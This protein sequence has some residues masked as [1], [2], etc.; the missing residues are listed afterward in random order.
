LTTCFIII[1]NN[2][3][4]M[5]ML[6]CQNKCFCDISCSRKKIKVNQVK[7][8]AT[9]AIIDYTSPALCTPVTPF[10]ADPI[11]SERGMTIE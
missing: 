6:C 2:I 8:N 3:P 4:I 9:K 7:T 1:I 11:F 10:P 5:V